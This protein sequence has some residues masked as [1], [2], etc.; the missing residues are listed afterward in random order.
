ME[1]KLALCCLHAQHTNLSFFSSGG[2]PTLQELIRLK[3]PRQ[4]GANYTTLG[5]LLLNDDFGSLTQA[6]KLECLGVAESVTLRILQEWLEGKGLPVTWQTLIN[7][8]RDIELSSLA[9]HVQTEK[10]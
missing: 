1:G 5:I 4:V 10:L 6:L 3:V 2:R 7:A 9:D 8:L